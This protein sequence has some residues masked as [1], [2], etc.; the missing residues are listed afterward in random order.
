M[1]HQHRSKCSSIMYQCGRFT[2]D[3][4]WLGEWSHFLASSL[5]THPIFLLVHL[6]KVASHL[7]AT[8]LRVAGIC[9]SARSLLQWPQST[10][11]TTTTTSTA[12]TPK[13]FYLDEIVLIKCS[14]IVKLFGLNT[15]WYW[16]LISVKPF[17]Y[18]CC[19]FF[20]KNK[21]KVTRRV[22]R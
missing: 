2:V 19:F 12:I 8:C 17:L 5:F 16:F 20:I 22:W 13:S 14:M 11:S 3:S 15:D 21:V 1:S 9:W 4:R 18:C 10:R 6:H 7:L